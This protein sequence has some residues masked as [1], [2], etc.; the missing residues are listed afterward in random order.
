MQLSYKQAVEIAEEQAIS[1]ILNGNKYE[2]TR[3]RFL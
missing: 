1:T 2:I 3:K